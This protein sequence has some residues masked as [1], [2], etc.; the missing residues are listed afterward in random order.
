[1]RL[2]NKEVSLMFSRV[3]MKNVQHGIKLKLTNGS[4]RVSVP[5]MPMEM[6]I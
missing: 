6:V 5:M 2:T 4:K 3:L 1:M